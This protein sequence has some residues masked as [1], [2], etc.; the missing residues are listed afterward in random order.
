MATGFTTPDSSVLP[1]AA[2]LA[3]ALAMGEAAATDLTL[4]GT[5][6]DKAAVIAVDGGEPRTVKVGQ[7]FGGA[8]LVSV[9][10]DRATVEIDGKR[11]VLVRGQTYSTG[12]SPS[13]R[14][15]AVLAAGPGG[16]FI[17]EG[18]VNGGPVR[19]L[20]D[21][22]AT[23]IALPAP[24]ARRL[25]IDYLKGRRGF[26]QT[27]AGPAPVYIVRLDTVRVGGIEL[28]QVDAIVIEQG[29]SIALLG[30]SFL[31]RVEMKRDGATMTL[32]RRF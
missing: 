16:H 25:G 6:G 29:L 30:M 3:A 13:G 1:R 7:R 27:A 12:G 28:Q 22:G 31:N 17:A 5:F 32:T 21:T 15:T 19:F 23:S 10:R 8:T 9:E 26:T 20:V 4:V 2:V 24:D 11:R 18:Q 14:Q